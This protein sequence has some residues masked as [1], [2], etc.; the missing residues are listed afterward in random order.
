MDQ[1]DINM[2]QIQ[3]APVTLPDATENSVSTNNENISKYN[4]RLR[5]PVTANK[6]PHCERPHQDAA[7]SVIYT[8]PT[9]ESS[10]DS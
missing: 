2:W 6:R 8:E 7:K 3:K 5:E 4:L 10:Q 1:Q 9:D